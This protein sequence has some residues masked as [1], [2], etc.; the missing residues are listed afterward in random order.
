MIIWFGNAIYDLR[1]A[2][3]VWLDSFYLRIRFCSG[4]EEIIDLRSYR[5]RPD[6]VMATIYNHKNE[7][8][9]AVRY[10]LSDV[11]KK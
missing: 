4:K 9:Y 2:E 11:Q 1:Y 7:A 10:L 6:S 8:D 5:C 3:K